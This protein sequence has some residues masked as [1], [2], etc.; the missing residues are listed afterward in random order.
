MDVVVAR[1]NALKAAKPRR[2]KTLASTVAALFQQQL[3]E[4]NVAALLQELERR[5]VITVADGKVGYE[6]GDAN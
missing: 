3:T 5:G 1:L 6:L 2:M 4:C